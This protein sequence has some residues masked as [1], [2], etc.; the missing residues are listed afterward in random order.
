LKY[1]LCIPDLKNLK[2][3]CVKLACELGLKL[4]FFAFKSENKIFET[5]DAAL[6]LDSDIKNVDDAARFWVD[7]GVFSIH[8]SEEQTETKVFQEKDKLPE[9]LINSKIDFKKNL[10][11]KKINNNNYLSERIKESN[12]ISVLLN[13]I[14]NILGRMLSGADISIILS[15]KDTEGLPCNVILMLIQYC[16]QIGKNSTRYIEKVGINWAQ[17][18]INSIEAVESKIESI[19]VSQKCW[20]RLG[21]IIGSHGRTPTT[22]EEKTAFLW[23]ETWKINDELV[24]I[25]YDMCVDKK[26]RYSLAYMNG[27]IKRW[28]ENGFSSVSDIENDGKRHL[29]KNKSERKTSYNLEEY[30]E[31]NLF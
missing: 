26:G 25:A 28:K 20:T 15:L 3:E 22:K 8:K 11:K 19:S 10:A 14:Q 18:G 29:K 6:F 27:I 2:K 31:S 16:S 5:E 17:E 13:E 21:K 23:F 4:L 9:P 30:E 1:L 12:E 24:K 7:S